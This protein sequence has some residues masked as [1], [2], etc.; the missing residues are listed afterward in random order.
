MKNY[1]LF[2]KSHYK[3]LIKFYE[4]ELLEFKRFTVGHP[5]PY[6]TCKEFE[7]STKQRIKMLNKMI[8]FFNK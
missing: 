7:E 4:V 6:L 2:L 3:R 5:I 8:E 1:H